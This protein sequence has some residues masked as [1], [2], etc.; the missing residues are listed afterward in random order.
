MLTHTQGP[1]KETVYM[2]GQALGKEPWPS[3]LFLMFMDPGFTIRSHIRPMN[4]INNWNFFFH[5]NQNQKW[6]SLWPNET[7]LHTD[8]LK[9]S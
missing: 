7:Q 5:T 9:Q 3:Y 6:E 4:V 8:F 2:T 1:D